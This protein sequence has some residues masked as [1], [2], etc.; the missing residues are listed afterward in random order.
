MNIPE[1]FGEYDVDEFYQTA[2]NMFSKGKPYD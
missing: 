2:D 1:R